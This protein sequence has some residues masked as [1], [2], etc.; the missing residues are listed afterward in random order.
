M[1]TTI[2]ALIKT[3]KSIAAAVSKNEART[4]AWLVDCIKAKLMK[5]DLK[6]L[7]DMIK[8]SFSVSYAKKL[9]ASINLAYKLNLV[10]DNDRMALLEGKGVYALYNQL[11]A[12]KP[13]KESDQKEVKSKGTKAA[14]SAANQKGA[15]KDEA[16]SGVNNHAKDMLTSSSLANITD[17][18][19]S[20]AEM[21]ISVKDNDLKKGAI[22]KA[23]IECEDL[24]YTI[25]NQ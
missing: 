19:S 24:V 5:E 23:L 8:N 3:G 20:L 13:Q 7:N 1:A 9:S 11:Q 10:N 17:I 22:E 21:A 25:I 18:L 12:F 15:Q 6:N 16:K 4:G 2:K 14:Q